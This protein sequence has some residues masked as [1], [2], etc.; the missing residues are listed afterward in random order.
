LYWG[1]DWN[2]MVLI[3]MK[4]WG[5]SSACNRDRGVCRRLQNMS[6]HW[7]LP[8]RLR[9]AVG[10]CW[11]VTEVSEFIRI[12]KNWFW[13]WCPWSLLSFSYANLNPP[14]FMSLIPCIVLQSNLRKYSL[15]QLSDCY[16][17]LYQAAIL[18]ES[19][20]NKGITST[21]RQSAD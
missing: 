16:I 19:Y 17:F 7:L 21:T 14:S 20:G 3:M 13:T 8:Q 6:W 5:S 11:R 12:L 9:K 18:R 4:L 2:V 10:F 15:W 1:R